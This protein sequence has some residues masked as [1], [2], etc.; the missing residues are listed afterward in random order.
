MFVAFALADGVGTA[1]AAFAGLAGA[2]IGGWFT[3]RGTI[4]ASR[5]DR[6]RADDE[7]LSQASSAAILMQDDFL[8]YQVTLARSL[9]RCT[10]WRRSELLPTQATIADRKTVWTKL[11]DVNTRTVAGAQGW[12]DYLIN[13]RDL[14]PAGPDAPSLTAGDA[15]TM[16]ETFERLEEGRAA[17]SELARRRA[18][19]FEHAFDM[20]QLTDCRTVAA[21]LDHTRCV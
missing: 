15:K 1:I 17:L 14:Q 21:L 19:T 8:H 5:A 10:W 4:V 11:N 13:T 9:D 18:S 6:Q 12:M 16:R 3:L 20:Q 7:A 2:A